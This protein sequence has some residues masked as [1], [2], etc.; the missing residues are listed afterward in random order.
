MGI[1]ENFEKF[2]KNI[3]D[4][5]KLVAVTK[6]KPNE[7]ILEAYKAG[8]KIF[9]E[10]KVQELVDK[11]ESLPGDIEW[12]MIGHLQRNKVKYIADFITLIHGVDSFK[13][14]KAINKE[15]IKVNRIISCLL[16]FHIAKEQSKFGLSYG[17]AV[18]FLDSEEYKAL[19]NVQIEGVM[20]MATFTEDE[21][22][23]RSEFRELNHIFNQLKQD[24]FQDDS[25]FKEISM[26]MSGDYRIALEEGATII[27]IGS[28]LFGH[29]N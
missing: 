1:K 21:N 8:Y 5:V 7:N 2:L 24:F 20:G 15:A 4:N 26:G 10:N 17:E 3:P 16:Q 12:H 27:R 29:R 6:T 11:Q 9:G 25:R 18:E 22:V 23:V 19:K 28:L 14:L 13:L